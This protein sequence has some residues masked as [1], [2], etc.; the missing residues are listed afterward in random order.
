MCLT[1][2]IVRLSLERPYR[3]APK[4]KR[5]IPATGHAQIEPDT[6]YLPPPLATNIWP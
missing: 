1:G 2:H 5:A 4:S 3:Y 6:A